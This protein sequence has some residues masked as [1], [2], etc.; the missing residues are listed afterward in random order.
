MVELTEDPKFD[1]YIVEVMRRIEE[2]YNEADSAYE[3][4]QEK[5]EEEA[6]AVLHMA[7]TKAIAA[8]QKA[9]DQSISVMREITKYKLQQQKMDIVKNKNS[10]KKDTEFPNLTAHARSGMSKEEAN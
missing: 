4:A 7:M 10:G 6:N 3:S 9:I 5:F 2:A 8:K 1:A